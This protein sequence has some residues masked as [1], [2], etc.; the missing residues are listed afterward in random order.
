MTHSRYFATQE[1][2]KGIKTIHMLNKIKKN[3]VHDLNSSVEGRF[4]NVT[5]SET[6]KHDKIKYLNTVLM[7]E[8]T[9]LQI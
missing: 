4:G 8:K 3:M 1:Q 9:I 5:I 6:E 7:G 2:L